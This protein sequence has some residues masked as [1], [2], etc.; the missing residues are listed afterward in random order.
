MN[1]ISNGEIKM[2]IKN[3]SLSIDAGLY[4]DSSEI[5]LENGI[6]VFKISKGKIN[7]IRR[8][9]ESG[10]NVFYITSSSNSVTSVIYSGTYLPYDSTQNV[11]NLNNQALI[12]GIGNNGEP[13]II[14]DPNKKRETAIITRKATLSPSSPKPALPKL[15]IMP[16]K[17]N[18]P[19]DT[20]IS[21]TSVV[22]LNVNNIKKI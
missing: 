12:D 17:L 19:T 16:V 1:L 8:I 11:I 21:T 7:D 13:S 9:Y 14:E 4:A 3:T 22:K 2:V 15:G 5:D 6:V 18:N 10:I 20:K